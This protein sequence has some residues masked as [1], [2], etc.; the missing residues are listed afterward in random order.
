MFYRSQD[1]N[2][3]IIILRNYIP[4]TIKTTVFALTEKEGKLLIKKG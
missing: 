4:L 1:K 2:S 3:Q